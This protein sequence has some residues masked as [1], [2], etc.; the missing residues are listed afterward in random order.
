MT[1]GATEQHRVLAAQT[2]R[3][4]AAAAQDRRARW[5]PARAAL[6]ALLDPLLMPGATIGILGAGNGDD[7]PLRQ[8]AARAGRVDLI[9]IDPRAAR[10]ARWTA[11]TRI[12]RVRVIEQDVTDG[13]A[14]A[15]LAAA[16]GGQ[17][18]L[19]APSRP[20]G[21]GPYDLVVADLVLSQLL[22]PALHDAGLGAA[23]IDAALL[24]H[25]QPLTDRVIA[26]LLQATPGGTVVLLHDVL[27]WWPGHPQPFNLEQLLKLAKR[28]PARAEAQIASGNQP[29][30]CDPLAALCANGRPRVHHTAMWR[31]P[32][33]PGTDYLVR[34]TVA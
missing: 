32:F 5:A 20:I 24:E 2:A 9:D 13:R 23:A 7:L 33:S 11:R 19:P 27:G 30:G 25:G 15:V 14:A 16:H 28:D 26:G 10:R 4:R 6:W 8:I 21:D 3:N 31:W 1:T 12:A 17:I 22:Y 34:A 18:P 29:Y